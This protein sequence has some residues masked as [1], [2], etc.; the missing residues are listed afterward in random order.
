MYT[1]ERI[2]T[3]LKE[4]E[5]LGSVQAVINLLEYQSS[6]TLHRWYERR[7]AGKANHH[8]SPDKLYTIKKQFINTPER[9]HYPD[10]NLKLDAIKR[11]FSLGEDIEYV[12]RDIAY[13]RVSIYS[14]Y[15]KYIKVKLH[16][17]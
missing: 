15:R 7:L 11:C 13:S 8:G 10:I 3:A 1:K 5:H 12:S 9:P 6:S 16:L 14:W 17:K 2:E 4:Y